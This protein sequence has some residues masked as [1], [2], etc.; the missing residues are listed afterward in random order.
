MKRFVF[1]FI[2]L[3]F[4]ATI[5]SNA[6]VKLMPNFVSTQE[7]EAERDIWPTFTQG[8]VHYQA[9]IMYIYGEL[10]ITSTMPDEADHTRPTFRSTYLMPIYSQY[11]K[12]Q[13]KVHPDFDDEMYLFLDIKYDP[14]K[15]Y[16]KL[17][18]QLAPYNEMLTYRVGPQWNEG[19]LRV[20]FVGN[21]PMRTFLQERVGFVGAQGSIADLEKEYDNKIMPLIGID[22]RNDIEWSGVGKMSFDEY[23]SLRD[24]VSKAHQ[25]GKKV[26]VYNLPDEEE[27]WDVMYTA[28]VDMISGSDPVLFQKFL[29][30]KQ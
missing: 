30:S 1:L 2:I 15:T 19:K 10:Y 3:Y 17:W 23:R 27:I 21:A 18:E 24:I 16:Q 26:R 13:G 22:F 5:V 4:S 6:Q 7:F 14:R 8:V 11:K 9:H 25:Q 29:E 28:G 20:I 12:N